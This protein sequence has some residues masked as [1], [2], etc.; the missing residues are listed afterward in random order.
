M[1]HRRR[2]SA[3]TIDALLARPQGLTAAEGCEV[4]PDTGLRAM[5]KRLQH[6]VAYGKAWNCKVP[7]S[8]AHRWFASQAAR[9][10][11]AAAQY[12][13]PTLRDARK[14][15]RQAQGPRLVDTLMAVVNERGGHGT[16]PSDL[17]E[18]VKRPSG[19]VGSWVTEMVQRGRV[20]SI[21]YKHIR[22][23]H[24]LLVP[25]YPAALQACQR[26]IDRQ[27]ATRGRRGS[28]VVVPARPGM[29]A[30]VTV[31][32]K[33]DWRHTAAS[34]DGQVTPIICPAP[35]FDH[36]YQVD[37]GAPL[38]GGFATMTRGEYDM[39]AS[40]WVAQV[41]AQRRAS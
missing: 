14:L 34:N 26:R 7:N 24:P 19:S 29:P 41:L 5:C 10:A 21:M 30:G 3:E 27:L 13:K 17:S 37:P 8:L 33:G 40:N 9:D 23:V 1:S 20:C 22:I 31:A 2:I 6:L 15:R 28:Y 39:P 35:K 11:W 18:A 16:L 32:G 4:C 36:R 25:L 38:V 12:H